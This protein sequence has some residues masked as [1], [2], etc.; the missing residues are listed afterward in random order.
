MD[1]TK[2]LTEGSPV[3]LVAGLFIY[4]VSLILSRFD[5]M[6]QAHRDEIKEMRQ[7]HV[8]QVTGITDKFN[9]QVTTVTDQFTTSIGVLSE[10]VRD[11]ASEVHEIKLKVNITN[12]TKE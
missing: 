11:L 10:S 9:E 4:V 8:A 3:A 6:N 12:I 5:D 1:I 2:I 7:E